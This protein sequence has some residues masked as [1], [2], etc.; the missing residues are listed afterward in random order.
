MTQDKVSSQ[1]ATL[2]QNRDDKSVLVDLRDA[3]V[4]AIVAGIV[5]GISG[6]SPKTLAQLFTALGSPQQAGEAAA[7]ADQILT[8]LDLVVA[9][10]IRIPIT[11]STATISDILT[12]LST[13]LPAGT[14]RVVIARED[15]YSAV[16][17]RY[18][19]GGAASPTTEEVSGGILDIGTT[20]AQAD[21][22]QL[23]SAS[24]IY[25]SLT[26]FVPRS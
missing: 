26:A 17:L 10:S 6:A 22:I 12:A 19:I 1:T 20:K 14:R 16:S 2:S 23:Y 8:A 21:T 11:A 3:D 7:A 25:A 18:H 5:A 24:S 13:E 9:L 4:S 15:S